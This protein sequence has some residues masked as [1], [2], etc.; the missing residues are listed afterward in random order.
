MQQP[1]SLPAIPTLCW[2]K[3]VKEGCHW[4]STW[5]R[6]RGSWQGFRENKT[7]SVN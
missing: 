1:S 3:Q 2:Y 6:A 4:V 5:S 7:S